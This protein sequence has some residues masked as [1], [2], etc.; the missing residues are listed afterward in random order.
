MGIGKIN[1]LPEL[2][3]LEVRFYTNEKNVEFIN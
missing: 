2:L 3:A 1:V